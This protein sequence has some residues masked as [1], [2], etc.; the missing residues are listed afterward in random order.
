MAKTEELESKLLSTQV[1]FAYIAPFIEQLGDPR[2]YEYRGECNDLGHVSGHCIC[3][4]PIRFEFLIHHKTDSTKCAILGS[5]C[6]G[7]FETINPKLYNDLVAAVE[8]LEKDI[9]EAK[10]KAKELIQ[11]K[12]IEE[13]RAVYDTGRDRLLVEYRKYPCYRV[14]E[15]LYWGIQ[16]T[17]SEPPQFQRKGAYINWYKRIQKKLDKMLSAL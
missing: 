14:P 10:K 15:W 6:I 12:E 5:E 4:H 11:D 7:H 8:R 17:P 9:A 1:Q 16:D 2:Q 3:G 13:L